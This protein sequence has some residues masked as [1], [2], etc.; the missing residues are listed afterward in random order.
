[1]TWRA[2]FG[3]PEEKEGGEHAV[4]KRELKEK[5]RELIRELAPLHSSRMYKSYLNTTGERMPHYM[6]KIPA[7]SKP[8]LEQL[9]TQGSGG[10]GGGGG[11]GG[12]DGS[13]L[14]NMLRRQSKSKASG[15]ADGSRDVLLM[16]AATAV[17]ARV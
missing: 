9:R 8:N 3:R 7:G 6:R 5:Q 13:G 1:M 2:I 16:G 17:N 12:V 10:G 14:M 4:I 15:P 11:G